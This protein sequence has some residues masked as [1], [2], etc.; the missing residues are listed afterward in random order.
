MHLF[1]LNWKIL[2][3]LFRIFRISVFRIF[4]FHNFQIP[5]IY[6]FVK[7]IWNEKLKFHKLFSFEMKNFR[8]AKNVPISNEMNLRISMFSYHSKIKELKNLIISKC[9]NSKYCMW[10]FSKIFYDAIVWYRIFEFLLE[11]TV[12]T[13]IDFMNIENWKYNDFQSKMNSLRSKRKIERS[14]ESFQIFFLT[15]YPFKW[16]TVKKQRK[17]D[18]WRRQ[19]K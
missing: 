3:H 1:F 9:E 6:I 8:N 12:I 5:E 2:F 4:A 16:K 14:Y 11:N 19:W 13:G 10:K 18:K 15:G 7:F 17:I